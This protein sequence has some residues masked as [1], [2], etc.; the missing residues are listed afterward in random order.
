MKKQILLSLCTLILLVTACNTK[1]HAVIKKAEQSWIVLETTLPEN[2]NTAVCFDEVPLA[3]SNSIVLNLDS[4]KT[5]A[6]KVIKAYIWAEEAKE[7]PH[8]PDVAIVFG[9]EEQNFGA[10]SNQPKGEAKADDAWSVAQN[11]NY[12]FSAANQKSEKSIATAENEKEVQ[13]G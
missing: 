6:G 9:N 5:A 11:D 13:G 10:I 12:Q 1:A 2:A 7:D 4:K 8:L 3:A